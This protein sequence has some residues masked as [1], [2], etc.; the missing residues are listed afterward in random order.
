MS[1]M[2]IIGPP[3]SGKGTQAEKVSDQL[4]IVPISTGDVF[5]TNIRDC[6]D[7][8]LEAQKHVDRGDFV[9]DS[10]TNAMVVERLSQ[11]DAQK[12]FLLDGY[13]RTVSQV[14]RLDTF[15]AEADYELDLAIE[16]QA[17]SEVLIQRLKQ[18]GMQS[19][20]SDDNESVI[21][22]RIDLYEDQ[23]R[24]IVSVYAAR[25]ILVQINGIGEPGEVTDR[26]LRAIAG[27]IGSRKYASRCEARL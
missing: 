9:P 7:L 20:R 14:E 25:K 17:D 24:P 6:T 19:A 5:R 2:L 22:H 23:T 10:I 3:G 27:H 8:G 26:V 13:P 18:R 21:R 1:R 12:G 4:G 16:L 11:A 15:L